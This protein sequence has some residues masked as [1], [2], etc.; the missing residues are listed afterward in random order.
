MTVLDVSSEARRGRAPTQSARDQVRWVQAD[1]LGWRPERTYDVWHDR[2]V[3]HFLTAHEDIAAYAELVTGAVASQGALVLGVF[4]PDGPTTCSGLP[5][6]RYDADALAAHF[7]AAFVLEHEERELHR[8]PTGDTQA[9]T[10]VVLRR[11]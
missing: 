5:T 4:A 10:W 2:A 11:R 8:T 9:F 3:F 6:S 7:A 1:L